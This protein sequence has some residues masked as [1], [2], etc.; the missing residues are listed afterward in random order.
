MKNVYIHNEGITTPTIFVNKD[1]SLEPILCA[2]DLTQTCTPN[3]ASCSVEVY[4]YCNRGIKDRFKI[5]LV[6][7]N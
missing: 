2:F 1:N 7:N 6:K 4:A 5:G 3:C